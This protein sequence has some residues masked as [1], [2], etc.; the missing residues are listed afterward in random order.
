MA[1]N[2]YIRLFLILIPLVLIGFVLYWLSDIVAYLLIAWVISMLGSPIMNFLQKHLKIGRFRANNAI[3]AV[4]TLLVLISILTGIGFLFFPII[5]EQASNLSRVDMNALLNTLEEPIGRLIQSLQNLGIVEQSYNPEKQVQD[6]LFKWFQPSK[7]GDF[8]GSFISLAGTIAIAVFSIL[9]ISFFFLKEQG[10]FTQILTNFVPSRLEDNVK[11]TVE[12]VSH[13]LSRY[14]GGL[15]IQIFVITVYLS[16]LLSIIG[17]KNAILIAFF[18]ALINLIPYLGPMIGGIFGVMLTITSSL[19]LNFYNEMLPLLVKVI[20]CFMS[21]QLI[22][23]FI[24]QPFIFS[25]Q[26]RSHPLEIFI[27][28][29]LGAKIGG[30]V[31]M[32]LAIPT[33]TIIRVIAR[34][35]LSEFEVV[36]KV[37][38]GLKKNDPET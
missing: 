38:T 27:L 7:I 35:F 28:I 1:Q 12:E 10:L 37:A 14:F 36:Q 8:L 11:H 18:A 6:E 31:G 29:M 9:F 17:V 16:I 4:L 19:D 3:C 33:Y 25:K 24:L 15:V 5:I 13:L 34:T 22:D 2:K 30:I 32:V 21:M 20:L 23:N 26:V